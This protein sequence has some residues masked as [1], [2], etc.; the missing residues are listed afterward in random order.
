MTPSKLALQ[1]AIKSRLSSALSTEVGTDPGIPG[2][3]V[4]DDDETEIRKTTGSTH[5]DLAHTIRVRARSEVSAKKTGQDAVEE[6]TDRTN[7]LNPTSP[8]HVLEAEL[9][10]S[11]MQ[12]TR[13]VDGPDYYEEII[14][15]T[16]RVTRS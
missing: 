1:E 4:G 13:R 2:V 9:T 5:T 16:Y 11:D 7:R 12:R 15:I 6:L 8:F 14:I 10:G 3:E